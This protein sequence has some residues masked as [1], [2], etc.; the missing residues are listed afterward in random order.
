MKQHDLKSPKGARHR[1]KRVG[2]GD[3]SGHGSYSGRGRK[4]QQARSGGGT[5]PGFEGGQLPL[6]LRL[7]TRKGFTNP[8]QKEYQLVK[9]E[10]LE[11]KFEA[12][13]EVTSQ[14]L[15]AVGLIRDPRKPV[16]V[17]ANGELSKPLTVTA[18]RFSAS[19][20]EKIQAAGGKAHPLERSGRGTQVQEGST[21]GPGR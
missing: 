20:M 11:R 5:R 8:F 12:G 14:E 13:A 21:H 10:D 17:L 15:L 16:K 7:P 18:H 9:V 1:R 4:G 3:A 19:A 6:I 2:R